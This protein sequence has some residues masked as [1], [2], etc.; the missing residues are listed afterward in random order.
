MTL[1]QSQGARP[2]RSTG[3]LV[4]VLVPVVLILGAT[5]YWAPYYLAPPSDRVRNPLH[6]WLRPS[7]YV[8]QTAGI[9]ALL[10]FLFLWLYPLRKHAS[11]L[12][13][14]G[15]LSTWLNVHVTVALV[16][17]FLAALHAGWRFEG[18]IGLGYWSMIVVC[19][20][21]IVGRYLY[22][23]IPRSAAGLELS[24]EEIARE[25]G[26]LLEEI[27]RA[28][29]LPTAQVESL[30]RSELASSE[31]LGV[32][33]TLGQMIKDEAARRRAV[34]ALGRISARRPNSKL[35]RRSLRRAVRLARRQMA[36]T[37]QARL[38]VATRRVFRLW[39]IAHRPFA[40][41]ALAALLVH[42]G[43]AVGLGMT[44]FW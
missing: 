24:A 34:R 27:S 9:V 37:Q 13:W 38:L 18:L 39:H 42:V 31:G 25:R 43:V 21:G 1:K 10:V 23:H 11:W 2:R 20:S 33:A 4:A 3:S 28:V 30:L 40:I 19:L 29:D 6:P 7:G 14:T 41:A 26:E 17:P 5:A 44:W 22:I 15:P 16:L 8:G 35:D 32:L 12:K 36:L